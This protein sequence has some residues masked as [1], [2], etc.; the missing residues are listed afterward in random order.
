MRIQLTHFLLNVILDYMLNSAKQNNISHFSL[1]VGIYHP[2]FIFSTVV[3]SNIVQL[4]RSLIVYI[5]LSPGVDG[6][7]L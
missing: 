5:F 2:I 6:G 1:N 4:S 3:A 7:G